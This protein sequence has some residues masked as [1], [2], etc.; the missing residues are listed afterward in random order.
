MH[1]AGLLAGYAVEWLGAANI[2]RFRVRFREQVWPGDVLTC[3]AEVTAVDVVTEG[4][5]VLVELTAT[6][7]TGGTALTASAAFLLPT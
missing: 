3:T 5:M 7:Q 1:S 2:R 6:R 4:R